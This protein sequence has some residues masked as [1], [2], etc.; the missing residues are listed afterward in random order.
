MLCWLFRDLQRQ[1]WK[2]NSPAICQHLRSAPLI[3]FCGEKAAIYPHLSWM[4]HDYFCI[5][6]EFQDFVYMSH[7]KQSH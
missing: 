7:L 6:G 2:M 1:R 3:P 4:T 5:P